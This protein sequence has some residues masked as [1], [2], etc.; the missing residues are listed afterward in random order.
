MRQ[1]NLR[2][3]D[4]P[5]R[6]CS[7]AHCSHARSPRVRP[8]ADRP[9]AAL[10]RSASLGG[11]VRRAREPGRDGARRARARC[12]TCSTNWRRWPTPGQPISIRAAG[13]LGDRL[14]TLEPEPAD[15]PVRPGVRR[16][17]RECAGDA[18]RDGL[19]AR[20]VR[21]HLPKPV[22]EDPLLIDAQQE[23]RSLT[24]SPPPA[25]IASASCSS[26]PYAAPPKR[27]SSRIRARRARRT[28][29]S[30][31]ALRVR[32]VRAAQGSARDLRRLHEEARAGA[33]TQLAWPAPGVAERGARRHRV[34][35]RP[36]A[37]E[38]FSTKEKGGA[39]YLKSVSRTLL[40]RAAH[41]RPTL[42]QE[43]AAGGRHGGRRDRDHQAARTAPAVAARL[44]PDVA[45]ALRRLPLPVPA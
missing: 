38:V 43:V 40:R 24:S 45:A 31:I 22:L 27:S 8:A 19:R 28:G 18:L 20:P 37:S 29:E 2:R 26:A 15:E 35:P 5:S 42:A 21:G 11:V 44:L 12:S 10:P 1:S 9:L 41:P 6:R 39:A 25:T 3:R 34:R 7:R 30:A 32:S 16:A 36:A 4:R 17:D 13:L 23:L 14:R 33:E